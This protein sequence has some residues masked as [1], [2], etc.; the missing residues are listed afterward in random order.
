[1]YNRENTG[2]N[3]GDTETGRIIYLIGDSN[4]TFSKYL[5]SYL[6]FPREIQCDIVTPSN[7]KNCELGETIQ[8]EIVRRAVEMAIQGELSYN[9]EVAQNETNKNK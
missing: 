6:R 5:I 4:T 9:Y 7:Q 8:K 1:M 3:Y 2:Y